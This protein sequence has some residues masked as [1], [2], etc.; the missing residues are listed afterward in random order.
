MHTSASIGER[1]DRAVDLVVAGVGGSVAAAS[2]GLVGQEERRLLDAAARIRNALPAPA[3][4][5]RFEA[6]LRSQILGGP[7][8]R[9]SLVGWAFRHPGRLI[10]TSAVGSAVGVG[11]TAAVWRTTRRASG[12]RWPYR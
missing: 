3:V 12:H 11:V 5:P 8:A 4:A 1:L 6:R 9:E 7:R 10:V 2:S